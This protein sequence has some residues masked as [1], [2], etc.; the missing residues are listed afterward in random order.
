VS[1]AAKSVQASLAAAAERLQK[2]LGD[3]RKKNGIE[4]AVPDDEDARKLGRYRSEIEKSMGRLL[5]VLQQ[6]REQVKA[7]KSSQEDG[8]PPMK[9]RLRVV[10]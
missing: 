5:E 7:A 4:V 6:V 9:F 2:P 10:R 3:L 1:N 8:A